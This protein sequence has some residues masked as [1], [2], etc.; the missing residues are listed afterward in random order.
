MRRSAPLLAV[1][2]LLGLAFTL[3]SREP[4]VDPRL[5]KAFRKAGP[6]RMDLRA[7]GRQRRRKSVFSTV[8]YW[9]P[10]FATA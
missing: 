4:Q 7:S 9:L 3:V 5:K 2:L 1:L 6:E 8:I 10:R